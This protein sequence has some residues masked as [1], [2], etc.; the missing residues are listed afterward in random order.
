MRKGIRLNALFL[1]SVIS[2]LSMNVMG[3]DK[4]IGNYSVDR[5]RTLKEGEKIMK[6]HGSKEE[7]AFFP[8]IIESFP[9][10]LHVT[11]DSR[12]SLIN[13]N[14]NLREAVVS[15]KW[16]IVSPGKLLFTGSDA[17]KTKVQ[18]F[19]KGLKILIGEKENKGLYVYF[20]KDQKSKAIDVATSSNI[21][22]TGTFSS[23]NRFNDVIKFYNDNTYFKSS[24]SGM[25]QGYSQ[26]TYEYFKQGNKEFVKLKTR[27]FVRTFELEKLK[28]TTG[29]NGFILRGK[30][31]VRGV[32]YKES[33]SWISATDKD[34]YTGIVNDTPHLGFWSYK[35]NSKT[36]D[37]YIDPNQGYFEKTGFGRDRK[38]KKTGSMKPDYTSLPFKLDYVD[39]K[40]NSKLGIVEFVSK[41]VM[42][43]SLGKVNQQRPRSFNRFQYLYRAEKPSFN[44]CKTVNVNASKCVRKSAFGGDIELAGTKLFIETVDSCLALLEDYSGEVYNFVTENIERIVEDK[45]TLVN[46]VQKAEGSAML[47]NQDPPTFRLNMLSALPKLKEPADTKKWCSAIIA[48]D[49]Y[50]SYL[51]KENKPKRDNN[52]INDAEL[53]ESWAGKTSELSANQYMLK[54]AKGLKISKESENYIKNQNGEHMSLRT[55]E[56]LIW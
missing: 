40:K 1:F 52:S 33:A 16:S 14:E 31:E 5:E 8:V 55:E 56:N 48:H 29:I 54:V 3:N 42:K 4:V 9:P 17:S 20:N 41:D 38:L 34:N 51:Y 39:K 53:Y 27:S 26:G 15:G 10:E 28:N 21:P 11:K 49:A 2:L 37:V 44:S 47:A 19:D 46:G 30:G 32:S 22:Y 50:H 25:S 36:P 18:T 13:S 35:Q 6:M 43:I 7:Q 45:I 24:S 23:D 12:F